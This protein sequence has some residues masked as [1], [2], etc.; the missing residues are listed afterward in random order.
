MSQQVSYTASVLGNI[1]THLSGLQGYDTMFHEL[2]QNADDAK[3]EQIFIDFRHNELR[4]WNSGV[5]S[6][7]GDLEDESCP[8]QKRKGTDCDFH[9]IRHVASGGKSSDP[10]N[11]GRFGIGFVSTY[12]ICDSPEIASAHC[13]VKATKWRQSSDTRWLLKIMVWLQHMDANSTE[14]VR[15]FVQCCG[16]CADRCG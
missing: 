11:I 12:Q 10:E 6:Y 8:Y 9:R 14:H 15:I 1:R 2:I 4:V 13:I 7:C 5:F 3:A 16:C